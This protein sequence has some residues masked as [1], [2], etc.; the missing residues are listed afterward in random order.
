MSLLSKLK[1][2]A[3]TRENIRKEQNNLY[4]Q[5]LELRD[6]GKDLVTLLREVDQHGI[7]DNMQFHNAYL[8]D[9]N[10]VIEMLENTT[11][12]TFRLPLDI[13]S[14]IDDVVYTY[15]RNNILKK[16]KENMLEEQAVLSR[17]HT[18]RQE[19]KDLEIELESLD[20]GEECVLK[21]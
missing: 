8:E 16:L 19:T 15:K 18:L 14:N 6:S 9:G 21:S 5:V 12:S 1:D 13:I 7:T 20:R 2:I 4:D 3:R 17:L 11:Y 10:V